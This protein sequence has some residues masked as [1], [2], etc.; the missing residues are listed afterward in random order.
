MKEGNFETD[1]VNML[2]DHP[3]EV[4]KIVLDL[5]VLMPSGYKNNRQVTEPRYVWL[6]HLGGDLSS[7]FACIA[8]HFIICITHN[9]VIILMI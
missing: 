3:L 1:I 6:S 5:G 9:K 4:V 7:W 8:K 2:R